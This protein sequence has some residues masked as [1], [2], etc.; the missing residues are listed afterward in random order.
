MLGW[1]SPAAR[2]ARYGCGIESPERKS[3]ASR[4]TPSA[5]TAWRCRP[6][7]DAWSPAALTGNTGRTTPFA[8]GRW[9]AGRSSVSSKDCRLHPPVSRSR[10]MAAGSRRAMRRVDVR[11]VGRGDG[12]ADPQIRHGHDALAVCGLLARRPAGRL[13][14]PGEKIED[15]VWQDRE[16]C[17]VRLWDV[18]EGREIGRLEGHT[19][20]V[21]C[22]AFSPSGRFLASGS[23]AGAQRSGSSW[24]PPTRRS[25]FGTW[26]PGGSASRSMLANTVQR[27]RSLPTAASSSPAGMSRSFV[28]GSCPSSS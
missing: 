7:D 26:K 16:H 8:F 25:V 4:P 2:T 28:S 5:L 23:G 22:V 12:Q 6:T 19:C 18:E 21:H 9:R 20:W 27:W 14:P 17:V 10:R 11:A 1:Q 24:K 13:R 3:A 15:G